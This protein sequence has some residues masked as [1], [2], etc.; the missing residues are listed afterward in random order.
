MPR[1]KGPAPPSFRTLRAAG[2][3][4]EK[5]SL[6]DYWEWTRLVKFEVKLP[7]NRELVVID[8]ELARAI[9]RVARG[10]RMTVQRLIGRWLRE[11]VRAAAS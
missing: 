10:R 8:E 7:G 9:R 6:A 1:G 5:H 4:W 11:K 3:F 2:D